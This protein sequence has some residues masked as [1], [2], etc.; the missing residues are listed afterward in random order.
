MENRGARESTWRKGDCLGY[1]GAREKYMLF[2][3]VKEGVVER[4]VPTDYYLS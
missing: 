2:V 4:Y 3:R 1:Y